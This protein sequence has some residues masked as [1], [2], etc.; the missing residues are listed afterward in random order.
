MIKNYLKVA[1]RN[2]QRSKVFSFINILGLAVGMGCCF[3]ILLYVRYEF[4][5]DTFHEKSAQIYRIRT[6]WQLEGSSQIHDTTAAPVAT[7]LMSDMPEVLDA[8]RVRRSGATIRYGEQSYVEGRVYLVDPS[9]FEIFD[10]ALIQGDPQ[11]VL[12]KFHSIVLSEKISEKYFG[13]DNPLGKILT[14]YD[15]F[16]FEVTGIAKNPPSNSHLDFDVLIRFD[17]INE[18]TGFNYLES[19]GAWNYSTYILLQKDFSPKEFEKKS[20]AFIKKYRGEDSTNPQIFH[21][22]L[23]SKINLETY[24]KIKY[25]YFFSAIALIILILACINFMNLSL[26]RSSTRIR[27]IGMRKVI[28]AKRHQLIRQFLGESVVLAFLALPLAVLFIHLVLRPFNVLLMT[29]L[30]T[31]YMA[32]LPFLL[33]LFG[34]T[35]LVSLISGSYPAFYLS[36]FQPVLSL[37][38]DLK[39]IG[40]VSHL[41]SL[42]VIVQF[43]I[44]VIL[45]MGTLTVLKQ[46]KYIQQRDL[47]FKKDFIVNIPILDRKLRQNTNPIKHELIKHPNILSATVSSFYP[48]S[49]PNQSVD[50]EGRKEDEELMM[51]WYSVDFD[52]IKTFGIELLDG[53][54]FS[55]DFPADLASAYI[56]NE[57]TLRSLGWEYGVGKRFMVER[58]GFKMGSVVGTMK[59]FHF[60]SLHH[61]IK[62]LAL[63]LYPKG[64][65]HFS[66]KIAPVNVSKTLDYIEK[67]FKEFAPYAPYRYSFMDEEVEEMYEAERRFVTLINTFSVLAIFIACL[68]L[69]GLASFSISR[70]TKEIGIRKILGASVPKIFLLVT[71]D[72]TNLVAVASIIAWPVGYFAMKKWLENFAFRVSVGWWIF[73]LSALLALFIAWLTI[74]YHAVIAA[75]KN[76]VDTLR[77]E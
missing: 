12:D 73:I 30:Q 53:R 16:D 8:V 4:S 26:A 29:H 52:F 22:Q 9:F 40:G 49:Y 15:K 24:G 7:A 74:T 56:L 66:L 5:Y 59:D 28:G 1:L 3:L 68:G 20:P 65:N 60:A 47:G 32:N 63:V 33:S 2:V 69:L 21:L 6:E 58:G 50:W 39:S 61:K 14:L 46:M 23:L 13:C 77:Y 70:R 19:W 25:I 51:A 75:R 34:I 72:F 57:S 42:L 17:T 18:I 54:D 31:E 10:F 55:K 41:R 62:P 76:P 38:G 35:L 71:K 44:S 43:S 45:I 11:N 67:T 48:G 64:G 36:R 37:K 27:E